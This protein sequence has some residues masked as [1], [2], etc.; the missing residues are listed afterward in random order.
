MRNE[1]LEQIFADHKIMLYTTENVC[2]CCPSVTSAENCW[3]FVALVLEPFHNY[4]SRC[5]WV[6]G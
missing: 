2:R 5:T 4:N 3:H 6:E 1:R